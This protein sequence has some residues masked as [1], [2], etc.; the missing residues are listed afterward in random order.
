MDSWL[1]IYIHTHTSSVQGK[2]ARCRR[3]NR[4]DLRREAPFCTL[5]FLLDIMLESLAS[6]SGHIEATLVRGI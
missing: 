4:A 2:K 5:S 1:T 6:D 3:P